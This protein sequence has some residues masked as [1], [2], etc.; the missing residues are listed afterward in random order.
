MDNRALTVLVFFIA[1]LLA[2]VIVVGLIQEK[3]DA[4]GV[5]MTLSSVITGIVGGALW[6][7]RNGKSA[8]KNGE[9]S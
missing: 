1:T 4:T 3:L 7:G 5:A 8:K 2:L 9:Q 6:R